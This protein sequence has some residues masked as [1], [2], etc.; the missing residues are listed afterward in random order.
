[1]KRG[2]HLCVL[3]TWMGTACSLTSTPTPLVEVPPTA[4]VTA[5][6][7][8]DKVTPTLETAPVVLLFTIGAH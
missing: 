8:Q 2:L 4:T 7:V 6:D 1:M 5:P 3:L